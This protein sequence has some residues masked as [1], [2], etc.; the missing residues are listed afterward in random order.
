MRVAN[1]SVHHGNR[2]D[3]GVWA[4]IR[5]GRSPREITQEVG[6]ASMEMEKEEMKNR[7]FF[8][9]LKV[10]SRIEEEER[11]SCLA[12]PMLFTMIRHRIDQSRYLLN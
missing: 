6:A 7:D 8:L 4:G 12:Y 11:V 2:P 3:S 1:Q 5:T 9:I 10:L